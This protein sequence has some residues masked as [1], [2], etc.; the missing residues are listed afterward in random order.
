M[1]RVSWILVALFAIAGIEALLLC[2]HPGWLALGV[3]L[4]VGLA[5]G[6]L[7]WS[8]RHRP[9]RLAPLPEEIG[10]GPAQMLSDWRARAEMRVS[11]ADGTRAD[12]DRY[13]RPMLAK[14]FEL[15]TGVRI[16]RNRRALEAAGELQF[17]PELW[18]WVDPANSALRDQTG[19][20]P[21][22]EVLEEILH[23]LQAR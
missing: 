15:S 16:S 6:T 19:R 2:R 11:R 7:V 14:E 20:A 10:N 5:L 3:T 22:R 12:W 18:R 8:L 13:L 9:M 1:H 17:G 21:G 4:P 23:R